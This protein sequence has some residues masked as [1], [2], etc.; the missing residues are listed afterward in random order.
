[1]SEDIFP[2]IDAEVT[3]ET[4]TSEELPIPREYAWDFEKNEFK[5]VDGKFQVVEGLE[6]IKIWVYK[7]LLTPRFRYPIYTENYGNDLEDLIG[8]GYSKEAVESEANRLLY[9]ALM[10]NPYIDSIE[11]VSVTFE[12][13]S[14]GIDFTVVTPYGEVEISV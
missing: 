10:V 8:S 9:E 6:A 7:T 2:F 4:T 14:L 3:E 1:M 11:N 5:L 12:G 13:D